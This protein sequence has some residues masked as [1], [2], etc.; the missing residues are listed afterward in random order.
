MTQPI[1]R[2]KEELKGG[3]RPTTMKDKKNQQT[4]KRYRRWCK[5][6]LCRKPDEKVGKKRRGRN[7]GKVTLFP[8]LKGEPHR[9]VDGKT[10]P[11]DFKE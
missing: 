7:K 4:A 1:K 6:A 2:K 8:Y 10:V 9:V 11:A 5:E 3:W